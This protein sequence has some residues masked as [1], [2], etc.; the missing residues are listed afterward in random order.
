MTQ[1]VQVVL[2]LE[3]DDSQDK[4]DIF[5]FVNDLI[6]THTF[7]ST[8]HNRMMYKDISIKT[9]KEEAEIYGNED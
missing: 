4:K 7:N 1:E 9:V 5:K 6:N 2:T 8:S 3:V